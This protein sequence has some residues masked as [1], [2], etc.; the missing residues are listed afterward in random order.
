MGREIFEPVV[1]IIAGVIGVAIIAVLVSQR[2]QT[3][4][5]FAAAGGAF[6]NIL[7][8]AVSPVTGAAATPNVNAGSNS[9]SFSGLTGGNILSGVNLGLQLNG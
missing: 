6:S 5:V 7:S 9:N 8:T 2:A 3:A 4:N 1:T